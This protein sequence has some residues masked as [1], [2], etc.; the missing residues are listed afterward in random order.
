MDK[1]H[2]HIDATFDKNHPKSLKLLRTEACY[3]YLVAMKQGKCLT[4][5]SNKEKGDDG[6]REYNQGPRKKSNS[7]RPESESTRGSSVPPR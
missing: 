4:V 1:S 2:G 6:R 7:Q 3:N 5:F